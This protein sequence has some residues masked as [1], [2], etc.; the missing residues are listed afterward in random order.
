MF[1]YRSIIVDLLRTL[2]HILNLTVGSHSSIG[3]TLLHHN[4]SA[5]SGETSTQFSIPGYLIDNRISLATALLATLHA[6]CEMTTL[7][8]VIRANGLGTRL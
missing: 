2:V 6:N 7:I 1:D 4:I 3:S 8:L 5:V